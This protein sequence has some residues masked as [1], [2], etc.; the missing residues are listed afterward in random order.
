[1]FYYI[2][3]FF[4]LF[5]LALNYERLGYSQTEKNQNETEQPSLQNVENI[6]NIDYVVAHLKKEPDDE[7]IIPENNINGIL[8]PET[9]LTIK[10]EII[11][12]DEYDGFPIISSEQSSQNLEHFTNTDIA[13]NIKKEPGDE[14]TSAQTQCINEI[15]G[16]HPVLTIK[17]EIIDEDEKSELPIISSYGSLAAPSSSTSSLKPSIVNISNVKRTTKTD[18]SSGSTVGKVV[19]APPSQVVIYGLSPNTYKVVK[20]VSANSGTFSAGQY[21]S[22]SP[23][24]LAPMRISLQK[25]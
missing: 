17:Q 20:C 4:S 5:F 7:C 23:N 2:C 13:S 15:Q 19:Q 25:F 10:Q 14:H 21:K 16:V 3:F 24:V 18:P 11:D 9:I 1:M 8:E 22:Y 6:V 12:E